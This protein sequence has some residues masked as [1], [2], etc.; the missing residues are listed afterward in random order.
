MIGSVCHIQCL[1][2]KVG[3]RF[4]GWHG[5]AS[6]GVLRLQAGITQAE[7]LFSGPHEMCENT[8][9]SSTVKGFPPNFCMVWL[10]LFLCQSGFKIPISVA[11]R[12]SLGFFLWLPPPLELGDSA[13]LSLHRVLMKCPFYGLI[14]TFRPTNV[15]S[16]LLMW[17]L[18]EC[19]KLRVAYFLASMFIHWVLILIR[20]NN[21][22]LTLLLAIP[23]DEVAWEFLL[24][25]NYSFSA[26]I[27]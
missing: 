1:H 21:I 4:W 9:S 19:N 22:N 13:S 5:S 17:C 18:C 26:L 15:R 6:A 27:V 2:S 11:E 8:W 3:S 25:F 20:I 24:Y 14:L 16:G 10:S 7:T 12:I 23:F